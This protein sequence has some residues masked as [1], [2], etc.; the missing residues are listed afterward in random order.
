[1]SDFELH[2]QLP[3]SILELKHASG[4]PGRQ[5]IYMRFFDLFHLPIKY[6]HR[7]LI[8]SDVVNARAATALIG[9]FDL[10]KL[11][12][13]NRLQQ[14]SRLHSYS[15]PMKQ[16]ARVIIT[17]APGQRSFRRLKMRVET[18]NSV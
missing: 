15:L 6:L 1:M 13:R 10:D 11:N 4:I 16:M 3:S 5:Y 7:K 12:A 8:L 17:D 9:I 14:L 2:T 18:R